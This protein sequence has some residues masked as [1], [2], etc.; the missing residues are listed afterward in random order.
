VNT[1]WL[2]EQIRKEVAGWAKPDSKRE[3]VPDTL[4]F[5]SN[6]RLT[7]AARTGGFDSV[8]RAISEKI[9]QM[10]D[11]P[12]PEARGSA[13]KW[14]QSRLEDLRRT[15]W[16]VWDGVQLWA[17]VEKHQEVRRAFPS[18]L[19]AA[20]VF[21][22]FTSNSGLEASK[23]L[24]DALRSHARTTLLGEGSVYF[25]EAG[26]VDGSGIP[27]HEIIVDL[28]IMRE[29][30]NDASTLLEC[31]L[32]RSEHM[33]RPELT[34]VNGPRH[35]I[36][37]GAPGNGK[38][39][40]SK[41][42]VQ[43]F[44]AAYLAGSSNLSQDHR[45]LIIAVEEVLAR[46]G[47]RFPSHRRWP[48]RLDLATYPVTDGD[49]SPT[50]IRWIASRISG[51]ADHGD[52]SSRDIRSWFRQWPCL[53]ILDGLD[54]ITDPRT[55]KNIIA[56]VTEF[57]NDVEADKGDL[58]VV[59]TTRPMGYT[60]NIAPSQ[61]HRVDLGF[62][63]TP[64]ALEYGEKAASVRLGKD[65]ERI[66]RVVARLREAAN[67]PSRAHLL[68]TPLQVLILTIILDSGR[69]LPPYRYGIF[70]G[71]YTAIFAREQGKQG[72]SG[73]LLR[74]HGNLVERLH[75]LAGLELQCRSERGDSSDATLTA[76]EV[77]TLAWKALDEYGYDPARKD[78][79][80][81]ARILAVTT[82]RLVL[83]APRK[84]GD[85]F[86][87]DV[88][89]LQELMAA[90]ELTQSDT[91]TAEKSLRVA[92]ASPHWRNTWL[93]AAGRSFFESR[94]DPRERITRLVETIDDDAYHRLGS[95]APVGP[96]LALDIIDDGMCRNAP[97]WRTRIL[98][99]ATHVLQLPHDDDI[100]AVVTALTRV[101]D[102][103]PDYRVEIV[104]AFQRALDGNPMAR[105]TAR[106]LQR[107][108][109]LAASSTVK[110]GPTAA[111]LAGLRELEM[112]AGLTPSAWPD[113][114]EAIS[115]AETTTRKGAELEAAVRLV[116]KASHNSLST[117]EQGFLLE[118]LRDE[119]VARILNDSLSL[120]AR[121]DGNLVREL[122]IPILDSVHRAPIGHLL[123][124]GCD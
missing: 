26:A 10:S 119:D 49:T 20:D 118:V 90:R 81:L 13:S 58:L 84:N 121:T 39:T 109:Q 27:L 74:D 22:F 71:Y 66:A 76:K 63:E 70:W 96:A 35:V 102:M 95:I 12:P 80:L 100:G 103:D 57:V 67:D 97:K 56:R 65:E 41:F 8:L 18:F 85:A 45:R 60:E 101:G 123:P 17:L 51:Q 105:F 112:S 68:R 91:P 15:E 94:T 36:V 116:E 124:C 4:V 111:A 28:P 1:N 40:I 6:V 25:D 120:L 48:M 64:K 50:I 19:T 42:L 83:L 29:R 69:D 33:L 23:H 114:R 62:F 24:S 75:E 117:N 86:G 31:I 99:Q 106:K 53:I 82:N 54:E 73:D 9:E 21:S 37:T 104:A 14:F 98:A 59:L 108:I 16:R 115:L 88:R 113:F 30:P 46:F 43:V 92:A 72:P 77:E 52:I 32:T 5:I 11:S 93:F 2:I 87:F 122:R 61:F 55:R 34:T 47:L 110:L 3:R 79:A 38:T 89:S 7:P 78:A 44:R 107:K